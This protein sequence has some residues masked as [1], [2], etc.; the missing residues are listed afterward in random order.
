[1]AEAR[2]AVAGVASPVTIFA[3]H[4][5]H[6]KADERLA[7]V[8]EIERVTNGRRAEGLA[9]LAGDLNEEPDGPTVGLLLK[10]WQDAT[11]GT[12]LKTFPAE[13]PRKQIDYV[14]FRPAP[15]WH[16]VESRVVE[17]KVASDHAPVLTVFE[18]APDAGAAEPAGARKTAAEEG[19][20]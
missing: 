17:E 10:R 16:V 13:A 5:D 9:I 4:L 11:A 2:V 20:Q 6:R 8:G 15:G 19:E 14:L 1:M 18:H 7:Q 3:T 12:A